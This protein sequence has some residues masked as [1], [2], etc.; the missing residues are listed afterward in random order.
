MSG[1]ATRLAR[2]ICKADVADPLS[3][4]FMCR[5]EI[6]EAAL[7]RMSGQGFK[8]L[9]D[10][11]ASSPEPPRIRELPYSFRER[12]HGASKLD[13]MVAWEY[14]M[15]LA[16]KLVGR[17]VPVRF[18]LFGLSKSSVFAKTLGNNKKC[19]S[20]VS[21]QSSESSPNWSGNWS[22]GLALGSL[23]YKPP[24]FSGRRVG[25]RTPDLCRVEAVPGHL[26]QR[27]IFAHASNIN[28]CGL[29]SQ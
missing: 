24:D 3:G 7:R 25:A 22:G 16:D 26:G 8:V 19:H 20:S 9:L 27:A 14:G 12:Q 1:A 10:L 6:F 4:L 5:R 13:T 23:L 11:L 15:L 29:R 18:A 21:A 2:I 17:F 28:Q